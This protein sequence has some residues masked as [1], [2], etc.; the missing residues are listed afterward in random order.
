MSEQS[1]RDRCF[2]HLLDAAPD[3]VIIIDRLGSMAMVNREVERLFGWTENEL[4]GR[5]LGFLIPPRFQRVF[6][7]GPVSGDESQQPPVKGHAVSLLARRRDGS[8]FPHRDQ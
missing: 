2:R 3:A 6:E 4:L 1:L 5:P 7:S 8:E